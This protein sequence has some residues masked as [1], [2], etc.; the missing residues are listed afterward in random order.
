MQDFW[1]PRPVRHHSLYRQYGQAHRLFRQPMGESG[2]RGMKELR[3][4]RHIAV[5]CLLSVYIYHHSVIPIHLLEL[6]LTQWQQLLHIAATNAHVFHTRQ[7]RRLVH[8]YCS[9]LLREEIQRDRG[10]IESASLPFERVCR[11]LVKPLQF[12]LTHRCRLSY[13]LRA[14]KP[15]K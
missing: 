10:K 6:P 14:Q 3:S 12:S 4:Y 7:L 15:S 5:V 13:P 2:I 11:H 9:V 8:P 1:N